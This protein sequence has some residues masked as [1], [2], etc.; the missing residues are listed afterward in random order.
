[1]QMTINAPEGS[2]ALDIASISQ[3]QG[4]SE[5]LFNAGQRMQITSAE[6]RNGILYI[7]VQIQ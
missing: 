6:S 1:M 5:I 7:S 2:H 4:E 3:Y